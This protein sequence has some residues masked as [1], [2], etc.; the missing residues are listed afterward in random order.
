MS[1]DKFH[2]QF[3]HN[4]FGCFIENTLEYFGDYLYPRFQHQVVG[5]YDK[6]VEYI[7]KQ[8]KYGREGD[9]PNLP[10]LILNPT[11]DMNLDDAQSLA[12]QMWRFPHLAPHLAQRLFVPIYQ[13][14]NVEV[15]VAFTRLKGEI[16]L[17]ALLPSFYEYFD[18]KI[19]I[20][21]HFGGEGRPI[22]PMYFNDFIILPEEL[23]NYQYSNDATGESYKLDWENNGA[24]EFLVETTNKNELV[25][26]GKLKPRYTLR[27]MSDG[28]TRYGGMDDVANWR[29]SCIVE[30]EIEIPTFLLL[31]TDYVLENI[32]FNLR[33]G[34][35]FSKYSDYNLPTN[36]ITIQR[37]WDSGMQESTNT[38]INTTVSDN[39]DVMDDLNSNTNTSSID[40]SSIA[41]TGA[42]DKNYQ[43]APLNILCDS[44]KLNRELIFKTRYFHEVTQ[45]QAD[46]TID[47]IITL[48][49]PVFDQALIKVQSKHGLMN[50]GDHYLLE[51]SG[52]DLKIIIK[53]VNLTKG[54]F[55]EIFIYE[56][57]YTQPNPLFLCAGSSAIS[58]TDETPER[59]S[60][61]VEW[62]LTGTSNITFIEEFPN[63]IISDV[64]LD[65]LRGDSNIIFNIESTM[66]IDYSLIGEINNTVIVSGEL[67]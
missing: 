22:E 41:G 67:N 8:E 3:I 53:N 17:L 33:F 12:K 45:E 13:D 56:T 42:S 43:E 23:V 24:Y 14:N 52:N 11:G 20:I 19:F 44:E 26:P 64:S 49:E 58:T 7:T 39:P 47:V 28:S 6:A 1:T 46:S 61:I 5:T 54:D 2:Y 65:T 30:Y 21:Q 51:N 66:N 16:E 10:A 50:Y 29:L 31:Q 37:H 62:A 35:T 34:S 4:V 60:L 63:I 48:P 27:G 15:N 55:I 38:V 36:E 57:P 32:D 9:K 18:L 40:D 25:V 59:S